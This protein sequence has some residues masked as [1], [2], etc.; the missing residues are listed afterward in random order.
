M[1]LLERSA[2]LSAALGASRLEK[3]VCGGSRR[4][5]RIFWKRVFQQ[6]RLLSKAIPLT[7]Q[8]KERTLIGHFSQSSLPH[9]GQNQNFSGA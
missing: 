5:L 8:S 6:P 1:Q 7:T 3:I 9:Q 2:V 4:V